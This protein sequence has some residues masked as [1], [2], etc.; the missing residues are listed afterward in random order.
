MS[1]IAGLLNKPPV[2]IGASALRYE[3]YE[4]W[5]KKIKSFMATV[6]YRYEH[7]VDECEK[8]LKPIDTSKL[9][10]KRPKD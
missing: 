9:P 5:S 1:R 7:L 4:L 8:S 10:T 6:D 2:F 3:D